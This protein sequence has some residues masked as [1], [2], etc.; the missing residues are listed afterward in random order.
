VAAVAPVTLRSFRD[1]FMPIRHDWNRMGFPLPAWFRRR[2]KRIDPKL[3][4]QYI[5][6]SDA[7]PRGCNRYEYPAGIWAICHRL[8]RTGFLHKRWTFAL[9][10]RS[11]NYRPPDGFLCKLLVYARNCWRR[12]EVTKLEEWFDKAIE[13]TRREKR[14][15]SRESLLNGIADTMRRCGMTSRPPG[16]R[17]F[18]PA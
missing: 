14:A 10:D 9:V 6:P 17:V 8:R 11:G 12:G 16:S 2:L 4:L 1:W 7:D 18:M 5:P 15:R 3:T 13:A